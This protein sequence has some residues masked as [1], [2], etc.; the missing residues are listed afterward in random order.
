MPR[1]PTKRS[2]TEHVPPFGATSD[3]EN[4]V[5]QVNEPSY[6]TL[7]LTVLPSLV[8]LCDQRF[9]SCFK[10]LRENSSLWENR[11]S[12]QLQLLPDSVLP[13]LFALLKKSHPGYLP[14][15]IIVTYFMRG[16]NL[17]LSSDS[18]PGANKG[19][20]MAIPR[21]NPQVCDLDISGFNKIADDA[22]AKVIAELHSLRSL[23][24]IFRK[25]TKVGSKTI[26]AIVKSC[27]RIRSLNLSETSVSPAAMAELLVAHGNQLEVLKIAG[28]E[29]WTDATF[30]AQLHSQVKDQEVS[31]PKLQTLKLR[32]LQLSDS[33]IDFLVSL[34]PNLRRL[35]ISF[36]AT[37]RPILFT[38]RKDI[39]GACAHLS[40]PRLEKL[41]LT[42]TPVAVS[43]LL[44]TISPLSNL[45]TLSLGALGATG[46]MGVASATTLNDV[47]L[48]K[49]TS[50]LQSFSNLRSVNL[51]SN[52]RLSKTALFDFIQRVAM[53]SEALA[54]LLPL[55][56]THPALET[57]IL[58]NTS[59][60]DD[61]GAY[62][63]CCCNLVRLEVEGTKFTSDGLFF[64]IDACPKLQTL[65]LTSCRG[66]KIADRRRFF[67][68]DSFPSFY[69]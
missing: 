59:V 45:R 16:S 15:E 35:D 6:R 28:L 20:I 8:T 27:P 24:L 37:K 23:N 63:A 33:S 57:L 56:G 25:C 2:R 46:S 30:M 66:V 18:L 31:M 47:T 38:S 26:T 39:F 14:H 40:A 36:T 53:R 22:F 7:P 55:D 21:L 3:L 62:I 17:S 32:G 13:K 9:V 5:F 11:I 49:L 12:H 44:Q 10:K 4:A 58:N 48:P 69:Q 67:E 34:S 1:R 50:A 68:V 65:N 43:D 64:I 42:S 19:T 52:T 54:A 41:S 60:G 51:V 29:R 61:S